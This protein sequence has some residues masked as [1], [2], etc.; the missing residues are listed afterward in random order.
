MESKASY[1]HSRYSI[2]TSSS[3]YDFRV[4]KVIPLWSY[5]GWPTEQLESHLAVHQRVID[6][7]SVL[8]GTSQEPGSISASSSSKSKSDPVQYARAASL[9]LLREIVQRKDAT[10][11]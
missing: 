10:H 7:I 2:S 6:G 11:R 9:A 8:Q 3:I 5:R 1:A 4:S